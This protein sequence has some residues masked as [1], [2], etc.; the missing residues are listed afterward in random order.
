MENHNFKVAI[1]LP[2]YRRPEYTER[3][4]KAL[5]ETEYKDTCFYL[6]DDGSEDS[7]YELLASSRLKP[8]VI[9]KNKV[10][11]GLRNCIIDFLEIIRDKNIDIIA[12]VD[13][14]TLMPKNWINDILK[15]FENSDADI[16]SPNILPS[17]AAFKYGLDDIENKGYRLSKIVGGLWVMKKKLIEGIHFERH[18]V[19]GL[20]GAFNILQQILFEKEPKIGWVAEVIGQDLGHWSGLHPENIKTDEHKSYYQEVGRNLA[21]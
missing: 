8:S 13:N 6:L 7:T 17:N 12:K 20:T 1:F 21:W 18:D 10:N 15:V 14:D 4:L 5:E 3:C 16:L 11:Q 2:A 9:L 19:L